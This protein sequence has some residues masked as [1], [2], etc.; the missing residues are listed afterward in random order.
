MKKRVLVVDDS[1]IVLE[2]ASEALFAKG[3]IAL[4]AL[5]AKDVDRFLEGDSRPDVIII[6]VMMPFLDGDRKTK[7]LKEDGATRDIPVLLMSSKTERELVQLALECGADG[8]IRKPF[9]FKEMV[10]KIEAVTSKN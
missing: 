3:Y 2:K 7:M 4:T 6:D 1:E 8:F 10:E 9:T 5:C